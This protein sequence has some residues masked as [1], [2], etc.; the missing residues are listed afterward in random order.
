MPVKYG[1]H[2][3]NKNIIWEVAMIM[4]CNETPSTGIGCTSDKVFEFE[5]K[6]GSF[7]CII[8]FNLY[9][10]NIPVLQIRGFSVIMEGKWH[11]QNGNRL[12]LRGFT[13]SWAG[14]YT[15]SFAD[16]I[17]VDEGVI[18]LMALKCP[19]C[20]QTSGLRFNINMLSYQHKV[21][22][23]MVVVISSKFRGTNGI[24]CMAIV[25]LNNKTH[26]ML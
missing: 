7:W 13:T 3:V 22:K 26:D 9:D 17:P 24:K 8:S 20:A 19:N 2:L 16:N 5:F 23:S 10:K 6:F 21:N 14:F 12:D 1:K 18:C 4:F 15:S 25:W 11:K